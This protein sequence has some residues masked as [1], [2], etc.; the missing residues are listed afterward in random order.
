[1]N[2]YDFTV[3]ARNGA[4]VPLS[5]YRGKVLLIV[6]TATACGF[7][8]QYAELQEYYAAHGNEDFEILD[9][10]CNQF[11]A[12]APG[13]D[14]EIHTF[15]TARYGT[16]FPRFKK[17]D[18]NGE[19]AIPLYK[20]L[21]GNTAFEGFDK[22]HPIATILEDM[23][24]KADPDYAKSPAIKWN[25]TKFVIDKNGDISGRFEPT[26]AKEKWIAAIEK[27]LA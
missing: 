17:I 24:S 10:P 15:C 22:E 5:D 13:D 7:T 14:T 19:D 18:V 27:A 8:P 4:M 9:F 12:H 2:A 25:F 6:N 26:A 21:T 11:G 1:M 16:T 20:W 23:F 3:K